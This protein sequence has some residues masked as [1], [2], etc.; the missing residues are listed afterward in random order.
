MTQR[1]ADILLIQ[2]LRAYVAEEGP[3]RPGGSACSRVNG[4]AVLSPRCTAT[5]AIAGL[6]AIAISRLALAFRFK[7]TVSV[8]PSEYLRQWRMQLAERAWR[9]KSSSVA[10]LAS[11]LGYAS[12]SAFGNAYKRVFG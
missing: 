12:E 9:R 4:S 8:P 11:A 5:S 7:A 3:A 10:G 6:S 1:L 2:A